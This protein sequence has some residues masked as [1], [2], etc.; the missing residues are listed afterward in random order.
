MKGREE[1]E[2]EEKDWMNSKWLPTRSYLCYKGI[3]EKD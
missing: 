2:E 3:R 1:E